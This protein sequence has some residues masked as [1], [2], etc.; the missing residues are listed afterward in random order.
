MRCRLCG[1]VFPN[2]ISKDTKNK[3]ICLACK[4]KETREKKKPIAEFYENNYM[5]GQGFS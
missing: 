4:V 3:N 1:K 5:T 2:Y